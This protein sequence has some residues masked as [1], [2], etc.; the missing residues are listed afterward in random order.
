MLANCA[1][2]VSGLSAMP[3]ISNSNNA[4]MAAMQFIQ[5]PRYFF[6]YNE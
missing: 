4:R 1:H 3:D 2:P 6:K 5:C